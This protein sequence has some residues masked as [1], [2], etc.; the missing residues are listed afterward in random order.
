MEHRYLYS[1]RVAQSPHLHAFRRLERGL[2]GEA[3]INIADIHLARNDA[4]Q[5]AM[6]VLRLD[7]EPDASV[8]KTIED[9]PEMRTVDL[10]DLGQR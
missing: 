7:Q 3:T 9:L 5:E 8:L 2:L 6:A 10:V 1:R 4:K